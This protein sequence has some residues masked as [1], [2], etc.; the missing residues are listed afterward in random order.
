M[1]EKILIKSQRVSL[2][3]FIIIIVACLLIIGATTANMF[4]KSDKSAELSQLKLDMRN[5]KIE[6]TLEEYEEIEIL[7]DDAFWEARDAEDLCL[8]LNIPLF[9]V[10]IIMFILYISLRKM[11]IVISDK[12]AYGKTSFG[13]RV[14]LPLDSISAVG[15]SGKKSIAISTASGKIDF[16]CIKN[17]DEIHKVLSDLLIERQNKPASTENTKENSLSNADELKK[18]KELLDSGVI[19]QEEFDAKKKQLLGL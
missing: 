11:E 2:I 16:K 8:Y 12:R 10:V 1:N 3:A 14:D 13:K 19:T 15:T 18:Y 4:I 9:A 7:Q 5:G 17:R 6:H